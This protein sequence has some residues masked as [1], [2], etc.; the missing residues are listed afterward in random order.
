M[1]SIKE[2]YRIGVGP[3]S[4]HTMGPRFAAEKF[5]SENK[6]ASWFR[7]TL[8]GSLAATG[9][10]H[11]TDRAVTEAL[12]PAPAEVIWKPEERLPEHPNAMKL[13][14][15]DDNNS[16]AAS[17]NVYSIGGGTIKEE[18]KDPESPEVYEFVSMEKILG[19]CRKEG[20]P[21]W[22]LVSER[23]EEDIWDYL[24]RVW[25]TMK[26]AVERGLNT[27]G[28]LPGEL[29]LERKARS[30][31]LKARNLNRDFQRTGYLSAY[32]L[33]V[34]EEN[35]AGGVVATAPTCGSSGV[36][37]S[38][39]CY[40]KENMDLKEEVILR[41]LATAG[42]IGNIVKTN[43]S[44]SGAMV[45][46]QGEVGTACAMASGAA[47]YLMG[48]T[49]HQVEYAAEMGMEHHLGLTCD[50]IAGL[51][52]IPCI[53]RN[54]FAAD[55]ALACGEYSLLSDGRHR[56]TFDNI[57]ETMRQTGADMKASYK[58]TSLGGLASLK[59]V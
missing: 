33:A 34:S 26:D 47:A 44:V 6:S 39:L 22:Q 35:A 40:L 41:A 21:L 54:A 30:Y 31:Y 15:L 52:Q 9:K 57:V 16:V 1:K 56:V 42:V 3:S 58:E 20:R 28:V 12:S 13:E 59:K 5:G 17:R 38:V 24:S 51:V 7:I 50:P 8:Y 18:G 32:A 36:L 49:L 43:A 37:P 27:E 11:L 46:C 25:N 29:K 19:W 2:I 14:A 10:G 45:G 23:E 55:R 53:E 48:G 4:S